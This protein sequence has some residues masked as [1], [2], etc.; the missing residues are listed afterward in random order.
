MERLLGDYYSHRGW[1]ED[2]VPAESKL[3]ELGLS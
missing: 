2:G 3:R 1:S